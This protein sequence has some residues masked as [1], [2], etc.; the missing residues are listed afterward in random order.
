MD[1]FSGRLFISGDFNAHHKEWS[2]GKENM[3]GKYLKEMIETM[4]LT[5]INN[6]SESTHYNKSQD[7][8]NSP[9]ICIIDSKSLQYVLEWKVGED[10]GSDHLPM[11]TTIK[12]NAIRTTVKNR[13]HWC[14]NKCDPKKFEEKL[15]ELLRPIEE[16][17]D[18]SFK[19]FNRVLKTTA[20]LTCK[21]TQANKPKGNPWW[22][23]DCKEAVKNRSKARRKLY[24][25]NTNTN[26]EKYKIAHWKAKK[27]IFRAKR[28]YWTSKKATLVY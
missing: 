12:L 2:K 1:K 20:K 24:K 14:F 22:N 9:D 10:L 15:T 7:E 13:R 27:T 25:N 8:F 28:N 4:S 6:P 18:F 19:N 26:K 16:K 3:S 23:E 21:R 5:T 11:E 17:Q